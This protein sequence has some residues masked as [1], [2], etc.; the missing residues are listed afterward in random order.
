MHGRNHRQGGSDPIAGVVTKI[1]SDDA[2]VVIDDT[3]LPGTVDLSVPPPAGG[4]ITEI[5]SSDGS[6][7]I[8]DPTGPTADLSVNFPIPPGLSA[9]YQQLT[10]GLTIA[11]GGQ[12]DASFSTGAGS[13][14]D[15]TTPTNPKLTATGM[16][17][18]SV[19]I[20]T[21]IGGAATTK[22]ARAF[23][24]E[25]P[26]AGPSSSLTGL[27]IPLAADRPNI[28]SAF[29]A[30]SFAINT[31]LFV[32]FDNDDTQSQTFSVTVDIVFLS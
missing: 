26:E 25:G 29:V 12:A 9:A 27:V 14:V 32:Q 16:Y 4:T 30:R 5:T 21:S 22:Y 10:A 18:I 6:V 23:L 8:T 11:A 3:T 7:T 15:L 1:T 28:V 13:L 2:S 31:L 20:A 24:A 19:G 17:L